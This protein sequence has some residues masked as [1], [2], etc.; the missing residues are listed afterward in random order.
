[1]QGTDLARARLEGAALRSVDCAEMLNLT[2]EQIS[3]A[4][5]DGSVRLPEG[6]DRPA[7]WPGEILADFFA[8]NARWRWWRDAEGLPWPPPGAALEYLDHIEAIPP[9]DRP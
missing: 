2:P 5:G 9:P 8:F 1:L 6:W 7:H 3:S 4:F